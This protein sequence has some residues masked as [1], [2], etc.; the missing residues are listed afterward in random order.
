MPDAL[1]DAFANDVKESIKARKSEDILEFIRKNWR[2]FCAT[3]QQMDMICE[4]LVQRG[5]L[6]VSA[7]CDALCLP[8]HVVFKKAK[9]VDTAGLVMRPRTSA[10]FKLYKRTLEQRAPSRLLCLIVVAGEHTVAISNLR[11]SKAAPGKVNMFIT[12]EDEDMD[13]IHIIP[14]T[15]LAERY[16][17]LFTHEE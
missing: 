16:P 6:T 12:A 13:D 3:R 7:L 5:E 4:E 1:L 8:D 10:L 17:T 11:A 2:L 9:V 14:Y 15:D